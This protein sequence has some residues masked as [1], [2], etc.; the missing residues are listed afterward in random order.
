MRQDGWSALSLSVTTDLFLIMEVIAPMPTVKIPDVY[1]SWDGIL[2]AMALLVCA[3]GLI[4]ALVKGWEAFRKVSVRDRVRA[5]DTRLSQAE[6]RLRVGDRLFACHSDDT[7]QMLQ[8]L[9]AMIMHMYSGNDREKLREVNRELS[10]YLARRCTREMIEMEMEVSS[11][12][13]ELDRTH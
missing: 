10:D 4:S 1:L 6:R 2:F 9:Q 5:L 13:S 8:T 11:H 3:A 7:G 12:E